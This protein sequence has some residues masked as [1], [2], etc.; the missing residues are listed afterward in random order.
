MKKGFKFRKLFWASAKH[1]KLVRN[2]FYEYKIENHYIFLL[3]MN[4]HEQG[5]RFETKI[6]NHNLFMIQIMNNGVFS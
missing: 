1:E 6:I 4:I 5:F 3:L 2:G